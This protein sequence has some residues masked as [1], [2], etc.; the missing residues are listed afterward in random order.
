M[1]DV[2][3]SLLSLMSAPIPKIETITTLREALKTRVILL[4]KRREKKYNMGRPHRENLSYPHRILGM[5]ASWGGNQ[6]SN[7]VNQKSNI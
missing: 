7:K 1:S 6:K 5:Y 4:M 3:S 2:G